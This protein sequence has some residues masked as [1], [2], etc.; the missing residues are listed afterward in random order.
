MCIRDRHWWTDFDDLYVILPISTQGCTFWGLCWYYSPFMGKSPQNPD[1]GGMNRHFPA[2]L[3]KYLNFYIM[4]TTEWIPTKFWQIKTSNYSYWVV[5]KCTPLSKPPFW[6]LKKNA[7][8]LQL[9]GCFWQILALW[10]T[11]TS[12]GDRPL[13][14][15]AWPILMKCS[16][17]MHLGPLHLI[18]N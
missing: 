5:P 3:A 18:S 8:S 17:V 11:W 7:I 14:L 4:K 13:K 15:T 10:Y 2:K 16:M 12:A 9:F 1:F 6:K